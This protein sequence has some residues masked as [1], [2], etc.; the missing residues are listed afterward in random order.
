MKL[1]FLSLNSSGTGIPL[2]FNVVILSSTLSYMSFM[3]L[4]TSSTLDFIF[5]IRNFSIYSLKY[6]ISFINSED[7]KYTKDYENCYFN[8]INVLFY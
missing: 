2:I 1:Y 3:P 7:D 5:Y 8:L 4:N 6:F